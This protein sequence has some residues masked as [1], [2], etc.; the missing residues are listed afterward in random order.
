MTLL[1]NRTVML[2][3]SSFNAESWYVN[4][5]DGNNTGGSFDTLMH[6]YAAPGIYQ[7]CLEISNFAGTC[8]D[9]YCLLADF[10][11]SGTE[12]AGDAPFLSLSPNPAHD[13]T[14]VSLE[15]AAVQQFILLDISGRAALTGIFPG[16]TFELDLSRLPAGLYLLVLDTDQGR[17]VRKVAV[18]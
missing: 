8:T 12:Q 2:V 14:L 18:R 15:G 13:R 7:I 17:V 16:N 1:P 3:D 10:S 5:G 4:F 9:T 11:S 6:T